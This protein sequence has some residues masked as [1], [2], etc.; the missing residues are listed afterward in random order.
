MSPVTPNDLNNTLRAN[1]PAALRLL[2]PLG[3]R[4][5]LPFGIPQQAA[6]AGACVRKATIGQITSGDGEPL[7]IP[8]LARHFPNLDPRDSLLYVPQ[9]GMARLRTRWADHIRAPM[10]APM[11]AAMSAPM[12][13]PI[14][15]TG[16]THAISICGELFTDANRPLIV[17]L[18]YWDNYDTI[19]SMRTEAP[20]RT[21]DFFDGP[22]APKGERQPRFNVAG[23][24]AMLST[25]TGPATLLLNFPGNPTGYAPLAD[26]VEGND[27][28]V[29]AILAHPHPLAVVCD[30]A[31]EGLYF[32]EGMYGRSIFGALSTAADPERHL[33]CKVDGAT[34]ELVF[35]GGRVGFL[36]FS[37]EGAAGEALAEKAAALIRST[38]SNGCAP[39]QAAVLD[40][41]DSPTLAQE[42]K[43]VRDILQHRYDALKSSLDRHELLYYP[44]NSGC[45][46]LLPLAD[47]L[48]AEAVRHRLIREQ[49]V[50]VIQVPQINALRVAFCSIEA[51]DI[52]DLVERMARILR[53]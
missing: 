30:D 4:S 35:F 1:H 25:L 27:G 5:A 36:T 47:G 40:A 53:P 48:E 8:S 50:G 11:S 31:Y 42:Q 15:T 49:S 39:S 12:S 20:I 7:A 37:A 6:E 19:V 3:L 18:P 43:A 44:F 29:A 21:F 28:I 9:Y 17:P 13:N 2:S 41:L 26:E 32:D 22:P 34:K 14:V 51:E 16:I 38:V 10:S 33:I 52:H 45:F 46:C 23:L 24:R